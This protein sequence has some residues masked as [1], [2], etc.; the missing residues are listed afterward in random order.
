MLDI[1]IRIV[2]NAIALIAAVYLVPRVGFDGSLIELGAIAAVFGLI[3]AYLRPI[4]KAFSLPLNLFAFGLVGLVINTL[5][6]LL[7]ALI[8]GQL[9]LGFTLAGW[10]P[11]SIDLDV[12]VAALL[13]GIV[14]SIVSAALAMIKIVTPRM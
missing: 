6:V 5:L 12:I 14:V 8:G 13:T 9:N 7:L 2:I 1:L 3:N 10:P 11:G 4:V